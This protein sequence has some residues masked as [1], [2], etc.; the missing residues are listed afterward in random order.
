[1]DFGE[2][3]RLS[4]R[5]KQ[6]FPGIS[7]SSLSWALAPPL[8]DS[9]TIQSWACFL[10]RAT[11]SLCNS[12]SDSTILTISESK[13]ALIYRLC[14]KK[15]SRRSFSSEWSINLSKTEIICWCPWHPALP[16]RFLR[17]RLAA[18]FIWRDYF[19]Q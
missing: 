16:T 8:N 6:S 12:R 5:V 13:Y 3:W 11:T 1:M 7:L 19:H 10:C 14:L 15:L 17:F 2:Q 4:P 18:R 9:S